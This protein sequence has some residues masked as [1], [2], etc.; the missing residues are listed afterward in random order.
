[1][2]K[3]QKRSASPRKSKAAPR[4]QPAS[5][6]KGLL[7]I[8][9]VKLPADLKSVKNGQ[10]PADLLRPI[11]PSGRMHHR[12]ALGWSV[13][14]DLAA[15]E[16]LELAHVGDYRPYE[17]QL[18]LFMSRMKDFPNAKAAKQTTRNFNGKTWYLHTGAPVATPATS[19]HGW[20][21]AIDAAL[22]QPNGQITTITAKPKGAK[23]SGLD[24]LLEFAEPC[25]FSW[26]L[27]SEPWHIRW[28]AGDAIPPMVISH[29]A[30]KA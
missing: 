22:R 9:K 12:A 25:G 13:L 16:G 24:F 21:L 28:V 7:P 2:K 3:S 23:R 8:A 4:P 20:G 1:M 30:S 26:E 19:N 6:K 15:A 17:Q 10:L 29:L 14:R 27:Q 18:S 5:P 11:K